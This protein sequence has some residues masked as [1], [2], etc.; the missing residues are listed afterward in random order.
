MLYF[1][2]DVVITTIECITFDDNQDY[3]CHR[4]CFFFF[5]KDWCIH[6][7]NGIRNILHNKQSFH[8]YIFK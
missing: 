3:N 7:T 8:T 2:I 6:F 4:K 1:I 5:L